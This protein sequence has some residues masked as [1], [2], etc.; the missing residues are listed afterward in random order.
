MSKKLSSI[1]AS[2]STRSFQKSTIHACI[3]VKS[4][5]KNKIKKFRQTF[6]SLNVSVAVKRTEMGKN[7]DESVCGTTNS[8]DPLRNILKIKQN[9]SKNTKIII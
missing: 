8:I 6:R 7:A 1:H 2:V 3:Q 5:A 4:D 9:T